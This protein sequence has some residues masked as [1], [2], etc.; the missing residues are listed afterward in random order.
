MSN[1]SLVKRAMTNDWL[2]E[3]GVP[4]LEEQWVSIRYPEGPKR[5]K[6]E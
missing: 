4:S 3:Q 2:A 5:V 1:N 6:S